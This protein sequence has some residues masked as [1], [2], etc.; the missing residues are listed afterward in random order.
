MSRYASAAMLD[1]GPQYLKDN[2]DKVILVDAFTS[3]Y[4]TANTTAKVAEASLVTGDFAIAG[5]DGAARVLT[6]TLTGKAGGNA[7]IGVNP[8]TNMHLVFVKTGTSEVIMVTEESSD[9]VITIGNPITFNSNPTYTSGQ[10]T[11]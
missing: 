7:I 10:P 9:Q 3:T 11:A 8:G 5:A 6:A 2:C 4:A 1:N